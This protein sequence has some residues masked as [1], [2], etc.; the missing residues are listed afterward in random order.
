MEDVMSQTAL[1]YP[2]TTLTDM[3]GEALKTILEDVCDNLFNPDPYYQQGGDMVRV[4][5][6]RTRAIRRRAL[7]GAS[8]TCASATH[9]FRRAARTAW[10]L[11]A[12]VPGGTRGRRR[13]DLGRRR[14]IPP[15]PQDGAATASERARASRRRRQRRARLLIVHG[16]HA[17]TCRRIVSVRLLALAVLAMT[18]PGCAALAVPAVGL[19]IMGDA[20]GAR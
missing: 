2:E 19:S 16:H 14:A 3:T 13:A 18:A 15:R 8:R 17:C 4:G 10:P 9:R 6:C 20:A 12:G 7:A 5:A 1:T 11:G